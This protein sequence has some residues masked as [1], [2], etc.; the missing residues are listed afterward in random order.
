MCL[1]MTVAF[2]LRC[3]AFLLSTTLMPIPTWHPKALCL[4]P[5]SPHTC[6]PLFLCSS[7]CNS[8]L[9]H[10]LP[11]RPPMHCGTA[12]LPACLRLFTPIHLASSHPTFTP[13]FASCL[14]LSLPFF[15]LYSVSFFSLPQAR[16]EAGTGTDSQARTRAGQG[17]RAWGTGWDGTSCLPASHYYLGHANICAWQS[18]R[19]AGTGEQHIPLLLPSLSLTFP[20]SPFPYLTPFCWHSTRVLFSFAAHLHAP[21]PYSSMTWTLWTSWLGQTCRAGFWQPAAAALHLFG[22]LSSADDARHP[23]TASHPAPPHLQKNF[24]THSSAIPLIAYC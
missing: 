9:A 1:V 14:L 10:T 12:L 8:T 6:L 17:G 16:R 5:P 22:R 23:F 15:L 24:L 3:T 20:L 7:S 2:S 18:S 4:L 21:S 19:Q 11:F 13:W